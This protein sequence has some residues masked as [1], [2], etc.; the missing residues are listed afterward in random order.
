MEKHFC[1]LNFEPLCLYILKYIFEKCNYPSLSSL[2]RPIFSGTMWCR[3][4]LETIDGE[5]I[6][7]DNNSR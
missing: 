2:Q 7:I 6:V 3:Y 5:I 4:A 1:V